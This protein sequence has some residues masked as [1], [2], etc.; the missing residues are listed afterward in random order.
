MIKN[1]IVKRVYENVGVSKP[2][3]QQAVDLIIHSVKNAI[4]NEERVEFRGFGIFEIRPKKL[5]VG[6]NPKTGDVI[7]IKA[8]KAIRF[9]PGKQLRNI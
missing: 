8:G 1:D 7:K 3:A 5:G 6:R 2:E 4:V 9:K